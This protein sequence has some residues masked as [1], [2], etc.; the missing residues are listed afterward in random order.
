MG[1]YALHISRVEVLDGH[2]HARVLRAWQLPPVG[3]ADIADDPRLSPEEIARRAGWQELRIANSRL[4]AP[5]EAIRSARAVVGV[6]DTPEDDDWD[7]DDH[8]VVLAILGAALDV[9]LE[10]AAHPR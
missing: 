1:I 10:T 9:V 4:D 3:A 5:I 2:L 7:G 8:P 6:E